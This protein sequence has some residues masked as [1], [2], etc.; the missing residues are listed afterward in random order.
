MSENAFAQTLFDGKG[1]ESFAPTF[2]APT[3]SAAP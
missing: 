3:V 1:K 2:F